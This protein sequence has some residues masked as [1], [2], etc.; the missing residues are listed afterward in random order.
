MNDIFLKYK[1]FVYPFRIR[2]KNSKD[3]CLCYIIY[4]GV[5]QKQEK[6]FVL[7]KYVISCAWQFLIT[8]L[9]LVNI[10]QN[11][12][13][14]AQNIWKHFISKQTSRLHFTKILKLILA[15]FVTFHNAQNVS[16]TVK[17][18]VIISCNES[19]N[20]YCNVLILQKRTF[21]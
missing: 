18:Y 16:W 20:I 3:T 7:L 4:W 15:S 19:R 1:N 5:A 6:N 12:V 10:L 14:D 9:H 8:S 13:D 21:P 2:F 11:F 17:I